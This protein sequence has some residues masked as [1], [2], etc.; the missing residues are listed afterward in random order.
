VVPFSRA[1]TH[2]RRRVDGIGDRR[3]RNCPFDGQLPR[4]VLASVVCLHSR[5]TGVFGPQI[6]PPV[7]MLESAILRIVNTLK[8]EIHAKIHVLERRAQIASRSNRL[9]RIC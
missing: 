8:L 9:A 6:G 1:Y 3:V 7:Y 2:T 4:D 5:G